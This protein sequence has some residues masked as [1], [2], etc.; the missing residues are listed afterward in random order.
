MY[1]NN[2]LNT[3]VEKSVATGPDNAGLTQLNRLDF[4]K[5]YSSNPNV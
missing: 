3:Y 1:R 2:S 4:H 5:S